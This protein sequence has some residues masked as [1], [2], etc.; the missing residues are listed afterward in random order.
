MMVVKM[1]STS[2]LNKT[3]IRGAADLH[4]C[5]C[6]PNRFHMTVRD[7]QEVLTH[8]A[9]MLFELACQGMA[10]PAIIEYISPA[11]TINI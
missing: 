7:K 9:N 4:T 10:N 11:D 3:S 2:G 8:K 6:S 1:F 5:F